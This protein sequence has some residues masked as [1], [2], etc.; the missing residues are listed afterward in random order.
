MDSV[1]EYSRRWTTCKTNTLTI[2]MY[3]MLISITQI[4]SV[5][6]RSKKLEFQPKK[7]KKLKE[8]SDENQ[9]ECNEIATN[10]ST[11]R[12]TPEGLNLSF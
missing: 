1:E 10:P 11:D 5:M 7:K 4:S 6:L 3:Q 2:L 9:T 8:P 12:A